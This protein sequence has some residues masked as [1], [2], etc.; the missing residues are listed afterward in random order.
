MKQLD[1]IPNESIGIFFFGKNIKD[2][3]NQSH[4]KL[5]HEDKHYSYES[6]EFDDMGIT[7]WLDENDNIKTI[8]CEKECFL[9]GKNLIKM[10]I[11]EFL[12]E[13][14]LIPDKNEELYVLINEN[15]GQNQTVYTFNDMGLMIWVWRKKIRSII[16][17]DYNSIE[18]E[19]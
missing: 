12:R 10:P 13:Y 9:N 7:L 11:E 8:I 1:L 17:S 6:Y 5:H 15:R 14:N 3:E 4:Y 2:Y 18:N 16:I 19:E